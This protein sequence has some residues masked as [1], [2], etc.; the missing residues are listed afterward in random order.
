VVALRYFNAAGADADGRHGEARAHETH[1][2]PLLLDAA[3]GRRKAFEIF[4]SRWPT[5]DGSCVRDYV[6]ITDLARAHVLALT[7]RLEA[8]FTVCNLGAGAGVSVRELVE[9]VRR[10]TGRLVP[11]REA[12][13]RPGDPAMLVADIRHAGRVLG[14]QP[15]HSSLD[16]I[17]SSAWT[18]R[19]SHS[20][21]YGA[22]A[23]P[24]SAAS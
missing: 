21:G 12:A 2:I 9:A 7:A 6:S 10:I 23:A 13:P 15:E 18:W 14:W 17:L 22:L 16:A 4:G 1:A 24:G 5:P 3:L 20:G 11:V 19:R 8:P